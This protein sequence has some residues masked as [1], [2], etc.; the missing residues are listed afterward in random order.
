MKINS[1]NVR[2]INASDKRKG[3]KCLIDDMKLDIVLL[4]ETK[5]SQESYEKTLFKWSKWSSFHSPSIGALGGLVVLWNPLLI[6]GQLIHYHQ[7][8]QMLQISNFEISFL[9]INVYG[10][11]STQDNLKLWDTLTQKIK[12]QQT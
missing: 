6:Q 4:Q 10:P 9:I 12:S 1:W 7:N 2:G 5:N 8:W 11:N 3:I